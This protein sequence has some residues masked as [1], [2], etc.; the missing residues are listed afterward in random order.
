MRHSK[1][2]QKLRYTLQH[3]H[4]GDGDVSM[5]VVLK[6]FWN[7]IINFH[8]DVRAAAVA[9]NFTLA[10]F[11]T[12]IFLFSLIPFIPIHHLDRQI[13]NF[14]AQVMPE[15]I[16][17]EFQE[18]IHEIVSKP[19]G[20]LLSLG[21]FLALYASTS[22]MAALMRSFNLTY[23][24]DET[25]GFF[26]SRL[27]AIFLNFL[28][29]IM[30]LVAIGVLIVGRLVLDYFFDHDILSPNTTFYFLKF[31]TYIAVFLVFFLSVSVIYYVAPAIKKR[32]KFFNMGSVVASMLLIVTTNGFSYYLSSI[33]AY[34]KLYGSI[35]T[36]IALMVWLYLVA[37]I[38]LLGFEINASVDIAKTK[39]DELSFFKEKA[40]T[41]S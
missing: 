29:T 9:Y 39:K 40:D 31:L 18:T 22:G 6:T 20:G 35:G 7:K 36:I 25:R 28:L 1:L 8:I 26:K 15:G 21:F 19:R 17:H 10:V 12:I 33:A 32:W 4:L 14:L 37:F 2:V 27:V 38:L 11:P 41:P 13:M 3:L 23:K 16:Y 24:T 34:N 30:L 5:Y